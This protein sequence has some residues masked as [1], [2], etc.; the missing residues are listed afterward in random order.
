MYFLITV[1]GA[2]NKQVKQVLIGPEKLYFCCCCSFSGSYPLAILAL[3]CSNV[4]FRSKCLTH[5]PGHRFSYNFRSATHCFGSGWPDVELCMGACCSKQAQY[6]SRAAQ[7]TARD[8]LS[9]KVISPMA[10]AV[11]FTQ[12]HGKRNFRVFLM[13]SAAN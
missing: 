9:G 3:N 4:R 11:D 5:W 12:K 6:S 10:V 2:R 7:H 8:S 13:S 1:Q